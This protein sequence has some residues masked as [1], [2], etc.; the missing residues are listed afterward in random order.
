MKKIH[1]TIEFY[2]GSVVN[3]D[4]DEMHDDKAFLTMREFKDIDVFSNKTFSI[5]VNGNILSVPTKDIRC[6]RMSSNV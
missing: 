5:V 4:S 2:N 3:S 6:I 1:V